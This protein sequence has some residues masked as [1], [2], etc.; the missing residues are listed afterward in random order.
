MFLSLPRFWAA[1]TQAKSRRVH[2]HASGLLQLLGVPSLGTLLGLEGSFS[3]ENDIVSREGWLC[4]SVA[5]NF[6]KYSAFPKPGQN[7]RGSQLHLQNRN[8]GMNVA[9]SAFSGG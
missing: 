3:Y 1:A 2:G 6:L 7:R 4:M 8:M 9:R 5:I